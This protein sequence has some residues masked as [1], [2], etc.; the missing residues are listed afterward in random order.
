MK[1]KMLA[2]VAA[3]ASGSVLAQPI[4]FNV[5]ADFGGNF[6]N[7]VAGPNTTGWIDSLQYTYNSTSTFTDINNNA[8]FDI[9]DTVL[10][11]GGVLT[12]GFT[13]GGAMGKNTI[14]SLLPKQISGESHNGFENPWSMTFGFNNLQGALAY[15]PVNGTGIKYTSGTI[16]FYMYSVAAPVTGLASLTRVFDMVVTGSEYSSSGGFINGYLSN[17]GN[18][19]WNGVAVG[20]IF[21]TRFQNGLKSFEQITQ[22]LDADGNPRKI[23]F[24]LDFNGNQLRPNVSFNQAGGTA[25]AS[26][27]H[28]GSVAFNVQVS[29]PASLAMLG[30]GLLGLGLSRSRKARK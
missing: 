18:V 17:F 12:D 1:L 20:N 19:N 28:D 15:D 22:T 30:L 14:S 2:L 27:N 8:T 24:A 9:G 5:G 23:E 10:T 29:E 26:A 6:A 11:K 7:K 13:F 21:N 25:S 4:Y 3:L 16:S